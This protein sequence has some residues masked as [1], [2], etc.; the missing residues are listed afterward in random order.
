[1]DFE[2][3]NLYCSSPYLTNGELKKQES[4]N[5]TLLNENQIA[6][7]CGAIAYTFFN[8]SFTFYHPNKTQVTIDEEAI[9]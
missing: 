8:D 6:S 2:T 1:L 9:V 4:W 7:P 5:G 3:G